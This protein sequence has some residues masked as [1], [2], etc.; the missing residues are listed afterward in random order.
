M[1][2]IDTN[3]QYFTDREISDHA[4]LIWDEYPAASA[5][6]RCR[7]LVSYLYRSGYDYEKIGQWVSDH[8]EKDA[9]FPDHRDQLL[10][11]VKTVSRDA[12]MLVGGER[13]LDSA[14]PMSFA[15]LVKSI[16]PKN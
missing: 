7:A 1:A 11:W 12:F 6:M 4:E 16:G 3:K 10:A 9:D 8:I 15:D 14:E 13:M 2:Y 5:N